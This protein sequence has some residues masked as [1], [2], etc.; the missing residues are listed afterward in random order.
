L[1]QTVIERASAAVPSNFIHFVTIKQK[2]VK[3]CIH[4]DLVQLWKLAESLE[5][6]PF[7]GSSVSVPDEKSVCSIGGIIVVRED[8][9][10]KLPHCIF[11][12]YVSCMNYTG[13]EPGASA[14]RR[15][16]RPE[17]WHGVWRRLM[18]HVGSDH[19]ASMCGR[20]NAVGSVCNVNNTLLGRLPIE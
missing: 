11:I 18:R 1:C 6:A 12:Q 9:K 4:L 7:K 8:E 16:Q 5:T 2:K 14:M 20:P 13:N 17:L 3:P 10:T 15:R 19:G